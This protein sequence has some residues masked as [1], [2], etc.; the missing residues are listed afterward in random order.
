MLLK[1]SALLEPDD[2]DPALFRA[3]GD[4]TVF[5]IIQA[6]VNGIVSGYLSK[7]TQI[8]VKTSSAFLSLIDLLNWILEPSS[9][10]EGSLEF[11][12]I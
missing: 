10:L 1:S 4:C 2:L 9:A 6:F 7:R 8:W 12:G 3:L 11:R 5:A